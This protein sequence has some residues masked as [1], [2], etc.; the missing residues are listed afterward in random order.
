[1]PRVRPPVR[2]PDARGRDSRL[3]VLRQRRPAE[4]PVGVCR[5]HKRRRQGGDVHRR[6]LRR[7]RRSARRRIV[8][9]KYDVGS[10][11]AFLRALR[12]RNYR[13][14]F[15]GQLI[16]L[17]GTWM[18][19]VAE[20]WLVYRLTGSATLLGLSSFASQIPVFLFATIGGTFADRAN[21]HRIIIITQTLSMIMPL[22][23]AAL[24]LTHHVKVWHVF[25]LAGCLGVVNAFDIPA[26]QA[27]L[28]DM[29]GHEDL[30]N[31]IALNSSM[32][33]GA[34]V[35]GPAVAGLLVAAVGEGWC[36]LLNGISYLAVI[37]GL[38]MM[39]LPSK[40]RTA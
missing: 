36:F 38:L 39:D 26:R 22:A 25:T 4:A 18:Q 40:P 8:W 6:T 20:S 3:P 19:S 11:P 27:F 1:M 7:V 13:L 35:V 34:R 14:F 12:H 24:T 15:G 21:R 28:V 17:V 30:L 23:L 2:A 37:A 16:S 32:V 33:N 29:V 31:A 9:K 5:R 10:L